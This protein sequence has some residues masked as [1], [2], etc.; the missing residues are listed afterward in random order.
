VIDA[1]S[2]SYNM[3]KRDLLMFTLFVFVVGLISQIGANFCWIGLL[4]T[5]PLLFTMTAVAYRD[6]FGM[7]GVQAGLL[8]ETQV[9]TPYIYTAPTAPKDVTGPFASGCPNCSAYMPT[10]AAF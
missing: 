2:K 6:C 4:A 8:A 10:S 9:N 1:M 5:Y 3:V 7:T